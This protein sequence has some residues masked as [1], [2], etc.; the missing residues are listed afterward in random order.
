MKILAV[1]PGYDRLG[2]AILEKNKSKEELIYSECFSPDKKLKE[3]DR[4]LEIGQKIKKII[5]EFTPEVL[6]LENLFFNK[7]QKTAFLVA[8]TRGVIIYEASLA[9]IPVEEFTPIQV[10]VAV[11]GYGR[12]DKNQVGEMVRRLIRIE[13]TGKILDDEYDAIAVGLTY[14]ACQKVNNLKR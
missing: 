1:D 8:E 14:F 9:G 6:A 4:I 10:K 7:N 11:T 3:N 2:I 5:K 13:K 12:S